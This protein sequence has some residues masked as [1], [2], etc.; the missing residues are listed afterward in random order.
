[1]TAPVWLIAEREIR[2][3]VAT[4]SFWVALAIGPLVGGGILLLSGGTGDPLP[5][6]IHASEA[7]LMRSATA[8]LEQAGHLDDRQFAIGKPGARLD[9]TAMPSGGIEA[10][11]SEAF[12]LSATGRQLVVRTLERDAARRDAG[13]APLVVREVLAGAAP[14]GPDT[15]ALSRFALMVMLWLTLTGSLGML[16]QT[17]VRERANRALESLLAS[18][19]SWEIL[20]GKLAG[21]GAISLLVLSAWLG[22]AA[23]LSLL[24]PQDTGLLSIVLTNLAS[25]A[26]LL[27]TMVIYLLAYAFYGSLTIALGAMARDVAAAQN[28]SRPMFVVLMAAFF[29][30]FA[31]VGTGGVSSWLVWV[32][33]F[34]PF[35]LL[36]YPPGAIEP[37]SQGF[38][39][40]FLLAISFGA[41]RFAA[42]RLS[43][44]SV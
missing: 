5:V 19:R 28:L 16:L 10:R 39:L 6:T 12:P 42:G 37:V 31:D 23:V 4:I 32:P 36:L 27:R 11:F 2:T 18:A 34:T 3:Y 25:P 44:A 40:A 43:Y 14:R 35:L 9:L 15:A 33:S 41:T 22:S 13:A 1:M 20:V 30:A 26:M 7:H 8:A 29:I 24:R 38:L 17:V 21:V